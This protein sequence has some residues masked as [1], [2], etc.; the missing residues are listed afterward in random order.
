MRRSALVVRGG[1]EGHDPVPTTDLFIP[2][3][4]ELGFDVTVEDALEVYADE[5]T[6]DRTDLVVQAWTNGEI[7]ADELA[8]LRRAVEAGT[9]LAGWHGGLL[10]S[11]RGA[12]DFHHLV[13]GQF[14]AHPGDLIDHE[15]RVVPDRAEHPVL[16]GLE[17]TLALRSEQYWVQ[18][19][20]ADD[21][22]VETTHAVREGQPWSE[23]VTVPVVW[24]RQ[25][26]A[27]RVFACT[28]GHS[29]ETLA[30]PWVFRVIEQG[31]VWA[32][33]DGEG[34]AG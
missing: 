18:T 7:L 1:W 5:D 16:E 9:G 28:V 4:E 10:D 3:L 27:G 14:V 29:V 20:A 25:W 15:I 33:R 26:G 22:L 34:G 17:P 24:T 23:P 19:D 30:D 12:T 6:M 2:R 13:G 8:G 31:M 32:A 11:F 21:V